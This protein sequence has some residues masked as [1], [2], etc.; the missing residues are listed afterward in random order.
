MESTSRL[1][2]EPAKSMG[3]MDLSPWYINIS[4]TVLDIVH[5]PAFYLKYTAGNVRTS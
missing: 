4:I 1:R 5:R 2:Y 3:S